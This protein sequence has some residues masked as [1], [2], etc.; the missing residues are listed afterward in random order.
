MVKKDNAPSVDSGETVH[1]FHLFPRLL[2]LV[3]KACI[4]RLEPAVLLVST[5]SKKKACKTLFYW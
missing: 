4:L 2:L 1:L 5:V 3:T